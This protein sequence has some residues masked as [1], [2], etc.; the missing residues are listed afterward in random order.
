MSFTAAMPPYNAS[1]P[2]ASFLNASCLDFLLIEL[3]PLAYRVTNELEPPSDTASSSS[4]SP[5]PPG[6]AASR[7]GLDDEDEREAASYRLD[8][9][10]YRVGQGLV[11]RLVPPRVP[12]LPSFSPLQKVGCSNRAPRPSSSG[13][14]L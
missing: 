13:L 4:G 10:G 7:G 3:V 1:D 14:H 11:E 2:T 5:P 9:L 8:M 6:D 12:F